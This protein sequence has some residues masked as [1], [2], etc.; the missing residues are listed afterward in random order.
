MDSITSRSGLPFSLLLELTVT[1][2]GVVTELG[3]TYQKF[4]EEVWV[5]PTAATW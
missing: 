5:Q 3:A 1:D 2:P 4:Q